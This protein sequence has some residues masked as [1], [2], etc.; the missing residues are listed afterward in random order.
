MTI[1]RSEQPTTIYT[2]SG[3]DN[4]GTRTNYTQTGSCMMYIT[5]YSQNNTQDARY[6]DVTHVGY[7]S[8]AMTDGMR[9][10]QNGKMYDVR[11]VN[12]Y[13]KRTVVFL[14]VV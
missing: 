1:A 7:T 10:E 4:Y 14:K 11:L 8:A 3:Y 13:A 5:I 2:A 9:V 12:D 6:K